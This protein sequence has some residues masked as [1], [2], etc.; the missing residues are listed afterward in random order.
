[1][2]VAVW[3]AFGLATSVGAVSR[4]PNTPTMAVKRGEDSQFAGLFS[5]QCKMHLDADNLRLHLDTGAEKLIITKE[6]IQKED[7][8]PVGDEPKQALICESTD[9][10]AHEGAAGLFTQSTSASYLHADGQWPMFLNKYCYAKKHKKRLFLWFGAVKDESFLKEKSDDSLPCGESATPSN[11]Y[12]RA[13]AL[14]TILKENKDLPWLVQVDMDAW[15]PKEHFQGDFQKMYLDN[16][17]ND[18][19][20]AAPSYRVLVNAAVLA[21]KNTPWTTN[22]M[23][24]WFKN[25]CGFK[26]QLSLWHSLF[27]EWKKED[28]TFKYDKKKML[29]YKTAKSYALTAAA[30]HF[31]KK[32]S[33]YDGGQ[34]L[35]K[36]A[37]LP[38]VTILPNRNV[39]DKPPMRFNFNHAGQSPFFCHAKAGLSPT[40]NMGRQCS[41]ET[42]MCKSKEQCHC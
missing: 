8:T 15:F 2:S 34:V 18:I 17:D 22:F 42:M 3:V 4:T 10:I 28:P 9:T 29:T 25:R 37:Q 33:G 38:H 7:G 21:L 19:V 13:L 27:I 30:D 12:F 32:L 36:K 1:M 16:Q 24:T 20:T 23:K 11:H 39:G 41:V 31:G 14:H 35:A 6:G 26:D 40:S 5:T